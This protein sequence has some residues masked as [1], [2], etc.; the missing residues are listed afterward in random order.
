MIAE[1]SFAAVFGAPAVGGEDSL[2]HMARAAVRAGFAI[3][4]CLPGTKQPMCTLPER[5]KKRADEEAKAAARAAG[6]PRWHTARHAC[7]VK[8][9]ITDEK[10][11]D[12]IVRRLVRHYGAINLG[13]ELSASRVIVV[14]VDTDAEND[15]FA[16]SWTA[17]TGSPLPFGMTVRSPGV[18]DAGTGEWK[19]KNGGHY[20]FSL[21]EGF[22]LPTDDGAMK[23][24]SGW[25]AMWA[26][27]QVL[28]PP[29]VRPEGAYLLVG[30][31]HPAP[32]WLLQR[33]L[34]YIA[35]RQRR[36]ADQ[37]A[38]RTTRVEGRE[39]HID[40]WAAETPWDVLLEPDG[41]FNTGLPDSCGCEI[42]TAPG[43]HASP[44]SATAHDVGCAAYDD[45]PG[46]APLHV[47]TDNPPEFLFTGGKTFTKIQYVALRDHGGDI[48]LACRAEGIEREITPLIAIPGVPASLAGP[49]AAAPARQSA[50]ITALWNH[51]DTQAVVAEAERRAIASGFMPPAP[52]A[53]TPLVVG[54]G[55]P[56]EM[57][58]SEQ[59]SSTN[60]H[61]LD[62]S[63]TSGAGATSAPGLVRECGHRTPCDCPPG[64]VQQISATPEY[65]DWAA[66]HEDTLT[67]A[68]LAELGWEPP[69]LV[70]IPTPTPS[71]LPVAPSLGV[72]PGVVPPL[73]EGHS[74]A[75]TAE[76]PFDPAYAA[77]ENQVR[78][79]LQRLLLRA[80]AE[81]RHTEIRYP[82]AARV[83]A[84]GFQPMRDVLKA[85]AEAPAEFLIEDWIRAGSYGVL[86]AQYK[87]GKTFLVIEAAL[88]IITGTPFLGIVPCKVGRVAMMHN[89]G[90][91]VEF[92]DRLRAVAAFKKIALTDEV[93][94]RLMI[95]E[96][97]TRMDRPD[98]VARLYENL[99]GFRPDL[100]T[101]DP[102]YMSAGDEADGKTLSKMGAVLGNLQGIAQELSSALLVTAHW[103][104][105]GTGKGVERW[106]GSGLA[107]WGRYL[108]NV[109]IDKLIPAKPYAE[110]QTRRTAV[111]LTVT[112][113]GQVSGT[114][115]V[116]REVWRDDARDLRSPMRYIVA[117]SE[118][119]DAGADTAPVA[120][121]VTMSERERLLRVYA[122]STA[123]LTK[124]KAIQT[125][126]GTAA[127][128]RA[129]TI[130]NE[131]FDELVHA[132]HIEEVG[133]VT[134]TNTAGQVKAGGYLKYAISRDGAAEV[135]RLDDVRTR[136]GSV[137]RFVGIPTAGP[138]TT[139][140][141]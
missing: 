6:R 104:Q 34:D 130:W 14:D 28:V 103:N 8:H 139:E 135:T 10:D 73:P 122:I 3:V 119:E 15:A 95:Q 53:Q 12:R 114:Y 61:N 117:A 132:G 77:W 57:G 18:Y 105:S 4:P 109:A 82:Y 55:A 120:R 31:V 40:A 126:R 107:E 35:G 30:D 137:A 118:S 72:D 75:L 63:R 38:R 65:G 5:D 80:E 81:R 112:L 9:A 7:G 11:S 17:A 92:S 115:S 41:W 60:G 47:W 88:S 127:R 84:R 16:V 124:T 136:G 36:S 27:R 116:H 98:E 101:L 33:V 71:E 42:W 39:P 102:W 133:D 2:V 64:P 50:T 54:N 37:E 78:A 125:A 1:S 100:L 23:D 69:K 20:W 131:A 110:D 128:G 62:R 56:I 45:S 13:V 76:A 25:I 91:M 106:S 97:A 113:E 48:Q 121:D 44:K 83:A 52:G 85:A 94:D 68:E 21:P 67:P 123:G 86:G 134:A 108:I 66:E 140:E 22:D 43:V 24:E 141:S 32:R 51:P 79:E 129:M 19:H 26:A 46:H 99:E 96:G 111:D 70:G 58:H 29:S 87:A 74:G 93:L 90:D 89:E 49:I 59:L 138:A